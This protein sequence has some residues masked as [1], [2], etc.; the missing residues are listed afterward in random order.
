[1]ESEP[2][3][4]LENVRKV[5]GHGPTQVNALSEINLKIS[6]GEFLAILGPSGSGKSTLMNIIGCLDRPSE[7]IYLL[8]NINVSGLKDE[9]LA[10]I[11][12]KKIGF[13]F[14]MFNLLPKHTALD[15]VQLPLLYS[16]VAPKER[17]E[18]GLYILGRM[19]LEGRW[20]HRPNELSGGECQRVAIARALINGPSILLADEPTGN[21]DS[22]TGSE[23]LYLFKRLNS[24]EGVTLILVT[25]NPEIANEARRRIYVQDGKIVEDTGV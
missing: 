9:E 20:H 1:M 18:K 23:I 19:G 3:I 4:Y 10:R 22:K 25:H 16:G 17:R 21:L 6:H 11:R 7:G 2:L 5:Y 14:Q 15:N 13:V 8:E 12:N 24:E